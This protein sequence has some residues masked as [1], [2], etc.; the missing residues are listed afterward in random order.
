MVRNQLGGGGCLMHLSWPRFN[1]AISQQSQAIVIVGMGFFVNPY[2]LYSSN[3][4]F[5]LERYRAVAAKPFPIRM[6]PSIHDNRGLDVSPPRLEGD[7]GDGF[8]FW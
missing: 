5:Q 1:G 2:N 6:D 4:D 7:A 8:S 3:V